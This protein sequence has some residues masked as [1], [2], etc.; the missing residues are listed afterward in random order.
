MNLEKILHTNQMAFTFLDHNNDGRLTN[1]EFAL[2]QS[3]ELSEMSFDH[4]EDLNKLFHA[5][6]KNSES[7]V[8]MRQ[9]TL[10]PW[11]PDNLTAL[12]RL[13]IELTTENGVI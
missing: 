2:L 11:P 5:M 9:G 4:P 6:D 10:L 8:E 3:N 13:N 12:L 1:D 7:R